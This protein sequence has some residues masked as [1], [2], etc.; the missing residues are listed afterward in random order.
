M[1][2]HMV[3][4]LKRVFR[5][6][7]C[8]VVAMTI[9]TTP[10][11]VRAQ[12]DET[13]SEVLLRADE[14]VHD[15]SAGTVRASGAVEMVNGPY[16]LQADTVT[17]DQ[18]DQT[19]TAS[20]NVILTDR[21]GNVLFG[22]NVLL[23]ADLR[24]GFI[25]K[26]SGVLADNSRFAGASALRRLKNENKPN[27]PIVTEMN[28]AVYSPCETCGEQEPL[29]QIK[30]IRIVHDEEAKDIIYHNAWLEMFGKP[31]A[32][33]PYFS[34]PDP[35]VRTRSGFLTPFFGYDGNLGFVARSYYYWAVDDDRDLTIE[36]GVTGQS[37][38]LL[39]AEWRQRF[40]KGAIKFTGSITGD[41]PLEGT[42]N[43]PS[44]GSSDYRGHLFGEGRFDI[45]DNWRASF[46]VELVTD[47]NYLRTYDY[48]EDDL[49]VT[50]AQ[51][52]GFFDRD[53]V[54]ARAFFVDDL[55]PGVRPQQ[56]VIAPYISYHALGDPGE[57]LGGRWGLD[58]GLLSL[59][60]RPGR[61]MH[62]L[63][64]DLSWQRRWTTNY[65][66]VTEVEGSW[67]ND[68]YLTRNDDDNTSENTNF[69]ARTLPLAQIKASYPLS[70]PIGDKH[71]LRVEPIAG[72][73]LSPNTIGEATNIA[74]EDSRDIELD[75]T[76]LFQS[77]RYSGR[78]RLE[79]G[80]RV[81]LGLQAGLHGFDGTYLSAF[82][83]QSYRIDGNDMVPGGSGLEDDASDIVGQV[84]IYP[85]RYVDFD[86]RFRLDP[87]NG[88]RG[89]LHELGGSF[90]VPRFRVFTSYTFVRAVE[91]TGIGENRNEL[92]LGT[93]W[94][95]DENWKFLTS[96]TTRL[97]SEH[98][99]LRTGGQFIYENDCFLFSTNFERDF[100]DRLGDDDETTFYVRLSFKTL[101]DFESPNI[102][103]E[104]ST[105]TGDGN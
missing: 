9:L 19:V 69:S 103:N 91:G 41:T 16:R 95:L 67:V 29:W 40:T 51:L 47:D 56:P 13:S 21:Q 8:G 27:G 101:G 94:V 82:I 35:S 48:T 102:F 73:T 86:Y 49:L 80:S 84:Q 90:G 74:N 81:T 22:E 26:I 43:D 75:V 25:Q 34:H 1:V 15:E 71:L 2:P 12:Q 66:L 7:M 60:R 52:E 70:R 33:T 3:D 88:V 68:L 36:A 89:R 96:T 78:D 14:L 54:S 76:N 58:A 28:K 20:G 87:D 104:L 53:Y 63:S 45:D 37:G 38:P 46:D 64:A 57:T 32:Y 77:N 99:L 5:L 10:N 31:V 23:S 105:L 97:G 30:A 50:Q 92:T 18:Q 93:R 61:D 17:Y 59:T 100:T 55:R 62:R 4:T 72:M 39:G 6:S 11:V 85:G 83:G 98:D 24:T 44:I 42:T 79:D 65:G